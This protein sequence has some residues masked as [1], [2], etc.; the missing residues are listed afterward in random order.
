MYRTT[1][2]VKG[3]ASEMAAWIK[4]TCHPAK[5][6]EFDARTPMME[7]RIYSYKLAHV[8]VKTYIHTHTHT[9]NV[10]T[11]FLS[12]RPSL[13]K[14]LSPLIFGFQS[15]LDVNAQMAGEMSRG[16]NRERLS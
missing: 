10:F 11:F 2:K 8:Y 9:K 3:L 1:L 14:A 16:K 7:G 12:Q 4:D 6:L 5:Q 15:Y 13:K